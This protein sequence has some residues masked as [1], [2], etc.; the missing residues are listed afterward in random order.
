[1]AK[2]KT[3]DAWL[4][5]LLARVLGI[6]VAAHIVHG[7]HYADGLTLLLVATVLGL[8]NSLLRPA[9]TSI[10]VLLSLPLVIGT[11]GLAL[12]FV[13]W[14]INA[15]LLY[16]TSLLVPTFRID[17]VLPALLGS[18]VIS[19]TSFLLL[20]LMNSN[21]GRPQTP[22][23]PPKRRPHNEYENGNVIDV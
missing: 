4:R 22:R 16:L 20:A 21:K 17:G 8:L 15:L 14:L 7:I 2:N 11:L 9:L 18:L 6:L 12:P 1:M 5:E 19:I 3:W 10:L 13:L 23:P